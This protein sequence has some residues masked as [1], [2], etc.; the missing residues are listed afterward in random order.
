MKIITLLGSAR[1]KGN[2]ATIVG[3]IEEA[4]QSQGHEA[5]RINV[6]RQKINGC[7]GC[8][9][10]KKS[11][12]AIACVQN[13]DANAILERM[14]DA[15]CILFASPV[16]F[17]GVTAQTKAIMDRCYAFVTNYHK[18]DHT[19]LVR[20][21]TLGLVTTGGGGYD[22]NVEGIF[23]AFDR[24]K[25]FLLAER[26]DMLHFGGCSPDVELSASVREKAVEFANMLAG[27]QIAAE[28]IR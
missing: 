16:Y 8:L 15:D 18:P 20:G 11:P 26:V 9:Q 10:C 2:T 28:T 14:L 6:A 22:N 13:D 21:K 19:S 24:F 5:A 3:W 23:D 17:W 12:D 7:L 4:L 25:G 27:Q 1:T